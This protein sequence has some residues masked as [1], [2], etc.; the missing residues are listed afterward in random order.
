MSEHHSEE[1]ATSPDQKTYRNPIP[2]GD[3]IIELAGGVVLIARKNAP[4][5]WAL[6]GDRKSVV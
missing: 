4:H 1:S 2:T 6:P 5:G 3:V